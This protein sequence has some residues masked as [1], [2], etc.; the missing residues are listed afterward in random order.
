L[1][2]DER[3]VEKQRDLWLSQNPAIRVIKIHTVKQESPSLLARIGGKRVPRVSILVEYEASAA[4]PVARHSRSAA[5]S[6]KRQHEKY[7]YDSS[8][9][10]FDE[11][12]S[13]G[14]TRLNVKEM[15]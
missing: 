14:K 13:A 6:E 9:Q 12:F 10:S 8:N 2:V 11:N 4:H 7:A 5:L 15:P 3:D 1:G